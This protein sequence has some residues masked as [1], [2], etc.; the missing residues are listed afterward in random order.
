MKRSKNK[1]PKTPINRKKAIFRWITDVFII[2][3]SAAVYAL[4]IHCFTAP[5]KIVPGGVT[6]IS[7]IIYEF[8]GI[9]IGLMYGLINIP[10]IIIG[11]IFLGKKLMIRTILSVAAITVFTDYVFINLPVYKGDMII[12]SLF[13]GVF[14]GVGLGLMYL[15]EGTSGGM[16]IVNKIINKYIPHISLGKI[17]ILMDAVIVIGAMLVFR[18]IE[19]GLYAI[20]TIFVC[21]KVIDFIIYGIYEGKMLLIFSDQY[22]EISRGIIKDFGRGV[23][24]LNGSGA[25][26]GNEKRVICC[27]VQKNEYTKIKRLVK[28]IDPA[29]FIIITNAGEVLG[30]GFQ[31]IN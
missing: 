29:A 11:F 19:V 22:Q 7:T 9:S 6:G 4:G 21:G 23:T 15:R 16:D 28:Q 31:K 25:Y 1:P 24:L 2:L 12:S 17:T 10:L 18:T 14:F 26:S 3:I 20:I 13:G 30:E 27:A 8:T 5:A